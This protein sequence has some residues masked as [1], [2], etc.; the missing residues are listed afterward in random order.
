M[1]KRLIKLAFLFILAFIIVVYQMFFSTVATLEEQKQFFVQ[2]GDTVA[3]IATQ[4]EE[5][6]VIKNSTLFRIYLKLKGLDTNI[7]A[8]RYLLD[9]KISIKSLA[10]DLTN[11]EKREEIT[12]T[13]FPGWDVRDVAKQLSELGFGSRQRVYN[14]LGEPAT[15]YPNGFTTELD[16]SLYPMLKNKPANVGLEG[17]L[18]ADTFQIFVNSTLE[19]VIHKLLAHRQS[20]IDELV[21]TLVWQDR[22]IHKTLTLASILE[23]EVKTFEDKK[24]VANLFERRLAEN[25]AFQADS[26]VHYVHG[27][28][29][30]VFTS[31][32]ERA[33]RNPWNTYVHPG[34]PPGPISMPGIE[35]VRAVLEQTPNSYSYFM[36]DPKGNVY[37][38]STLEGHNENVY[39]YLR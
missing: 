9:G 17:Y 6:G 14:L 15:V 4:L 3:D 36:T 29:G 26:T 39:R 19:E 21:L 32:N 8:G 16:L 37:Y 22:N 2:K 33:S 10:N 31:G 12:I 11:P 18:G 24:I 25:W 7:L 34:L 38:A 13:I 20:E 27:G 35:S 23:R 5:E 1:I 28:N 30:S